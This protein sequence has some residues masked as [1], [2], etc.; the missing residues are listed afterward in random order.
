MIHAIDQRCRLQIIV[1]NSPYH[2]LKLIW[3]NPHQSFYLLDIENSICSLCVICLSALSLLLGSFKGPAVVVEVTKMQVTPV[4]P[5][6]F[7]K[8]RSK[9]E[10]QG[11]QVHGLL[12]HSTE[13]NQFKEKF[14]KLNWEI[15][16]TLFTLNHSN[17]HIVLLFYIVKEPYL[18][19]PAS[20]WRI[21]LLSFWL[22]GLLNYQ[23][24]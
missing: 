10:G 12:N 19:Y 7:L 20:D 21:G 3:L 4:N 16:W 5:L 18:K 8:L 11:F 14:I 15:L 2:V 23:H 24:E 6:H 13:T 22:E 1:V 9:F 17:T